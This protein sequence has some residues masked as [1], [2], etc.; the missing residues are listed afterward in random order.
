MNL[1]IKLPKIDLRKRLGI[2]DE[3]R[4]LR[5][6]RII[7]TFG[8]ELFNTL[9]LNKIPDRTLADLAH[10]I[11]NNDDEKISSIMEDYGKKLVK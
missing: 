2:Y 10:A 3:E 1:R 9:I 11:E 8:N 5:Q 6:N 7:K 4:E